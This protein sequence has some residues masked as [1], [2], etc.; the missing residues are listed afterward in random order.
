MIHTIMMQ[1]GWRFVM[2]TEKMTVYEKDVRQWVFW[3]S[4]KNVIFD[5]K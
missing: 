3:S 4:G 2:A 5:V 1:D